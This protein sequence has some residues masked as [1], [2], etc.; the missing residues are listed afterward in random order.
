M[1]R[2]ST[3][4]EA[5]IAEALG[6][7]DLLLKRLEAVVPLVD[8]TRKTL[9]KSSE[10]IS[11]E[12]ATFAPHMKEFTDYAKIQT[13]KQI[14]RSVVEVTQRA[15]EAQLQAMQEAARE[16]FR[17]EVDP[18]VRQVSAQLQQLARLAQ[19][20]KNPWMPWLTHGS[21]FMAGT[22]LTWLVVAAI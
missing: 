12:I 20:R 11:R 9:I 17:K 5:L 16:M 1:N 8:G 21:A 2:P 7:M 6:D 19:S 13:A 10:M 3:A 18:V 22:A 4:K 14:D 15:K